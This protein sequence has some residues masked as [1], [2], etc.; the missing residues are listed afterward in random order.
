MWGQRVSPLPAVAHVDHLPH[1]VLNQ[2]RQVLYPSEDIVEGVG[3][4]AVLEAFR[5]AREVREVATREG[6]LHLGEARRVED[7][8]QRMR[9]QIA[10]DLIAVGVVTAVR[11]TAV[12]EHHHPGEEGALHATVK[13][14]VQVSL[15]VHVE[16]LARLLDDPGVPELPKIKEATEVFHCLFE[17]E[18]GAHLLDLDADG[19][20][21]G[22]HEEL[23]GQVDELV[24]V[25]SRAK[26]RIDLGVDGVD[27][28]TDALERR[29]QQLLA[30]LRRKHQAVRRQTGLGE[31]PDGVVDA[32]VKQRL[33]HLV[34]PLQPETRAM[35][36]ALGLLHQRPGHVFVRTAQ[37]RQR[38]HPAAQV[39]LGGQLEADFDP[40]RIEFHAISFTKRRKSAPY[41]SH[42]Y[43]RALA[44]PA[45]SIAARS[46]VVKNASTAAA[47][48]PGFSLSTSI[49]FATS[50][51]SG[52][53]PTRVAMTGR[54]K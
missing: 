40:A 34:Q 29:G 15:L 45:P 5:A 30:D 14:P 12:G 44:A 50:M 49:P 20:P 23:L 54:A 17:R 21:L 6:R 35:D 39:A 11:N 42:E 10:E 18:T 7:L 41:S 31:E 51:I 9:L 19:V 38:A 8:H 13:L 48:C 24:E 53:P 16:G 28:D 52:S 36:L 33:S 46:H 25:A 3:L 47:S 1:H 2:P 4:A 27:A 22:L 37:N 32:R 43:F 26:W